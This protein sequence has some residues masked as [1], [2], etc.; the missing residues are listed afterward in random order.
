VRKAVRIVG[1]SVLTLVFVACGNGGGGDGD[2]TVAV[3]TY[4][5]RICANMR[6]YFDEVTTLSTDFAA[7]VDAA[8]SLD[9]QRNDV[10]ALFDDV[11]EAT[12]RLISSVDDAGVPDIDNGEEVVVAIDETITEARGVFEDARS[13]VETISVEN[14]QA[15]AEQLYAIGE[16]I[17]TSLDEIGSSLAAIDVPELNA[18]AN[19]NPDCAA[20]AGAA[21]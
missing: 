9:K 12:D 17:Q 11:L 13:E 15:F 10:L 18:A 19:D 5:E 2:G 8:A 21:G 16:T 7:E 14:P 4:A 20:V 6:S 3:G 1:A